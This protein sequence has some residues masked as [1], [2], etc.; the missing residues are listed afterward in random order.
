MRATKPEPHG[1]RKEEPDQTMGTILCPA[2]P[3]P[4]IRLATAMSM[5]IFTL[6]L[7]P[8][9]P[10]SVRSIGL[11]DF[12]VFIFEIDHSWNVAGDDELREFGQLRHL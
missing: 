2:G 6:K 3:E 5:T 12:T 8:N 4:L 1:P 11:L 9:A 7:T 10:M